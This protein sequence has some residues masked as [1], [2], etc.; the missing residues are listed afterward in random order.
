MLQGLFK[1]LVELAFPKVC[2]SCKIQLKNRTSISDTICIAC[3]HKLPRNL[4]PFCHRCG[5]TLKKPHLHKNIC[6][7]CRKN[8][9]HFDRAF[10]PCLYEGIIKELI[11]SFKYK[12]KDYLGTSLS[13]VMIEFIKEYNFP[14][15]FIDYIVPIPLHKVRLREREFNQAEIL[16]NHLAREFNKELQ[17]DALIRLRNSRTQ[18]ELNAGERFLNVRDAFSVKAGLNLKNKNILL[19]DD[20]LTSGATA[21]E[22]ALA[23]KT[24]GAGVIFVLTLAN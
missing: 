17:P 11:H 7:E 9:L 10:S 13:H 5:R 18:T 4:P 6:P 12:A 22:A 3:W 21:S 1:G 19:V 23:L 8:I 16:G 2:L 15:N 20:V 14:I 24:S